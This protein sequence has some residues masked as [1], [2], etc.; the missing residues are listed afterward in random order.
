LNAGHAHA[1][2]LS[3]TLRLNGRPLLIDPGTSTYTMD[4]KLRDQLRSSISHNTLSLHGRSIA[5]PSGPFHWKTR[6]DAMLHASLHNEH[7]DWIEA[8][9]DAYA[10]LRVR[11]TVFRSPQSGWI[12]L[13][14][15]LGE[16]TVTA[17]THWHFDPSWAVTFESTGR[18]RA[19]RADGGDVWLLHEAEG[20]LLAHGDADS[21]LGWHA[22]VYGTLVPAWTAR[23]T[24]AAS[25]PFAT[26]AW[27]GAAAGASSHPPV[28]ERVILASDLRHQPIGLRVATGRSA[29]AFL[30]RPGD[31]HVR[32]DRD[33]TIADYQTDARVFHYAI[34]DGRLTSFSLVDGRHALSLRDGWIS[35]AASEPIADLSGIIANG[36]LDLHATA[37]PLEMRLHGGALNGLTRI[38]LNGRDVPRVAAEPPDTLALAA[39]AWG[40][41]VRD[42]LPDAPRA[43]RMDVFAV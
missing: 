39:A 6:A 33:C 4:G 35:I 21:G 2:A 13:D 10:P 24:R 32:I 8:S 41:T 18:L 17:S 15:V 27:I 36:T 9:H 3:I 42:L 22:P 34:E 29:A 25:A 12:V 31:D 38:R 19:A 1:D 5:E 11:R 30:F 28:L 20:V 37:P 26:A 14:E 43:G 16:G 23:T 40:A 7:F